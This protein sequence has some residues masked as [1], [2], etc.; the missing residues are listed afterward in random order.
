MK[1][2]ALLEQV[3]HHHLIIIKKPG[4]LNEET[5]RFF[6]LMKMNQLLGCTTLT[7]R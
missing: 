4:C 1:I 5:Y 3:N 6:V 2:S 7:S